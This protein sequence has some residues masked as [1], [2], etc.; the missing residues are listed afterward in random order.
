VQVENFQLGA[1]LSEKRKRQHLSSRDLAKRTKRSD[2]DKEVA[3]SHINKIERGRVHPTFQTLQKIAAA[4]GL[5]LII[6]L[7]GGK[8]FPDVVTVVSASDSSQSL[9]KALNREKLMQLL[10]V[11]QY[12]T[13]EQIEAVLTLVR[14]T[15]NT[16]QPKPKA[17]PTET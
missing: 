16:V 12:F 2:G 3:A 15:S 1:F 14:S 6:V 11:C 5:P 13:D 17:D 8:E 4:L 9:A 7:D 10:L